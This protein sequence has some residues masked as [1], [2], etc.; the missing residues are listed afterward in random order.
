MLHLLGEAVGR[1][2]VA[3]LPGRIPELVEPLRGGQEGLES[4][5]ECL[6]ISGWDEYHIAVSVELSDPADVRRYDG[7]AGC[8]EEQQSRCPQTS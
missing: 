8:H 3:V 2:V 1:S 5:C 6:G 7:K 4:A